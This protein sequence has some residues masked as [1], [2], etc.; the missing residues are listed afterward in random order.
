MPFGQ[1]HPLHQLYEPFVQHC[2]LFLAG[3]EV[4]CLSRATLTDACSVTV[5]VEA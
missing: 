1:A 2:V 3:R 5:Y 4:V